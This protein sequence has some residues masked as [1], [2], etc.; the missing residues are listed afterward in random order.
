MDVLRRNPCTTQREF[1][2]VSS[3]DL[4][5]WYGIFD[6]L[7]NARSFRLKRSGYFHCMRDHIVMLCSERT[8]RHARRIRQQIKLFTVIRAPGL[9]PAKRLHIS[10]KILTYVKPVG[11][12]TVAGHSR[13][14]P[15]LIYDRN[16]DF[17]IRCRALYQAC[18]S[19]RNGCNRIRTATMLGKRCNIASD[20]FAK[21]VC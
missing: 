15:N 8:F 4:L 17:Y 9:Y 20:P 18:R 14:A 2:R 6:S 3:S 1:K 16:P 5:T 7:S 19:E 13:R 11:E 10:I 21:P 12:I